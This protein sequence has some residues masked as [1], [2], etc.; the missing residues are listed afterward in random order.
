MVYT[1][2]ATSS[3]SVDLAG[4]KCFCWCFMHVWLLF[5]ALFLVCW[6]NL[7]GI[8]SLLNILSLRSCLLDCP[9]PCCLLTSS[10][11]FWL[12]GSLVL[13]ALRQIL[14]NS[15]VKTLF[16]LFC[17]RNW[18]CRQQKDY[19]WW[20]W[21]RT[22]VFWSWCPFSFRNLRCLDSPITRRCCNPWW[23]N[24][25]RWGCLEG[26]LSEQ[27]CACFGRFGLILGLIFHLE[28]WNLIYIDS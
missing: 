5:A 24:S 28:A 21:H 20:F 17:W 10:S 6:P 9:L 19:H 18:S 2:F 15:Y 26:W 8:R 23:W 1:P 11:S 25:F 22:Y 13:G 14:S 16:L 4:S 12:V 7:V 3:P 27:W